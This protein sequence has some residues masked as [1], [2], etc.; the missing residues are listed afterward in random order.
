MAT[1]AISTNTKP[2]PPATHTIVGKPAIL[3]AFAAELTAPL[4]PVST[5]G[6][7][8][9]G[10]AGAAAGILADVGNGPL[11]GLPDETTGNAALATGGHDLLAQLAGG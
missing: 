1:I 9:R 11:P 8:P 2:A 10:G 3:P 5:K 4:L 6:L 7:G